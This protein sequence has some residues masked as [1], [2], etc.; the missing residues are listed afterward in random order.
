MKTKNIF[1]FFLILA[2][3]M[4]PSIT[5]T[6][7]ETY[8]V[9][10]YLNEDFIGSYDSGIYVNTTEGRVRL[11]GGGFDQGHALDFNGTYD[12]VTV[13]DDASLNFSA[14][15]DFSVELWVNPDDLTTVWR[16]IICKMVAWDG[17]GIMVHPTN[18]RLVFYQWDLDSGDLD[19]PQST[20]ALPTG[21]RTHIVVTRE[22]GGTNRIYF[23]ATARGT[24]ADLSLNLEMNTDLSIGWYRTNN[25]Y[26]GIADEVRIYNRVINTTEISYSFNGGAG[27]HTP[28]NETGLVLWYHFNE[29]SGIDINDSSVENNDGTLTGS[30][31][32]WV[33]GYVPFGNEYA[34]DGL[35]YSRNLLKGLN[36]TE[37][38]SFSY[39]NDIS[40]T[41]KIY[42]CFSQDNITFYNSTSI[43]V[44]TTINGTHTINI[45]GLG[46]KGA[47]FFYKLLMERGDASTPILSSIMVT[48]LT[49][50]FYEAQYDKFGIIFIGIICLA[51]GIG[52]I[53]IPVLA[54]IGM[55]LSLMVFIP[56]PVQT[57]T[58][59]LGFEVA[60]IVIVLMCLMVGIARRW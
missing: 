60:T 46:L 6:H 22:A 12:K 29:G 38:I 8:I 15:D 45:E 57:P 2:S 49:Q 18:Q 24:D 43:G 23:N 19:S 33:T 50:A 3:L 30:T 59:I 28:L 26:D 9:D 34:E 21:S 55:V 31:D 14:T 4:L 52:G 53:F 42:F 37:I 20:I 13:P 25:L 39:D 1:L 47:K 40:N 5:L 54:L 48:V 41:E 27:V 11:S 44:E 58:Y 17:W 35:L 51:L 7:A 10:T 56:L 16:G 32:E 36:V